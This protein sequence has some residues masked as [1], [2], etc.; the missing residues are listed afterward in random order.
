[1]VGGGGGG[2]RSRGG[3]TS[4]RLLAQQE[5]RCGN[6]GLRRGKRGEKGCRGEGKKGQRS[7]LVNFSF[8]VWGGVYGRF[9]PFEEGRE[10]HRR[11]GLQGKERGDTKNGRVLAGIR[12]IILRRRGEL[13]FAGQK[14]DI[15]S[16]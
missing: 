7:Q 8:G 1:V 16:I 5:K 3:C 4:L 6:F 2:G 10:D 12:R 15:L 13:T 11:T 9:S 14:K